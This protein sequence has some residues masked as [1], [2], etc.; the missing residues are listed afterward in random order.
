MHRLILSNLS[1]WGAFLYKGER[2]QVMSELIKTIIEIEDRAQNIVRDS[3]ER[4]AHFDQEI[5]IEAK[6]IKDKIDSDVNRKILQIRE[7]EAEF[8][9]NKLAMAKKDSDDKLDAMNELY[10]ES[11]TAWVESIVQKVMR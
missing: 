3:R 6:K 11:K 1:E 2:R 8:K 7:Q 5:E 10:A 4:Q 9:D